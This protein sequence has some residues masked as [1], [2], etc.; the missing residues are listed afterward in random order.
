MRLP[1]WLRRR[2]A[3]EGAQEAPE[4]SRKVLDC[5]YCGKV[6]GDAEAHLKD[7]AHLAA[8]YEYLKTERLPGAPRT[9]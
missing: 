1:R 8:Q 3:R 5:R 9:T 2:K 4:G 7:P 6:K